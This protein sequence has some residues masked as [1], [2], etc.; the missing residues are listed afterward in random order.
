MLILIIGG[1]VRMTS[2]YKANI[3]I[4]RRY[5]IPKNEIMR[6][7]DDEPNDRKIYNVGFLDY[8]EEED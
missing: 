8:M 3:M 6:A 2:G 4:R 5:F 7:Y 1:R